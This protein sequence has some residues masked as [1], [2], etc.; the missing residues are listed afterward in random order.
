VK[1]KITTAYHEF[2]TLRSCSRAVT[3]PA[4][5]KPI[6]FA[7]NGKPL[8]VDTKPRKRMSAAEIAKRPRIADMD[9][10][11]AKR[12]TKL[13]RKAAPRTSLFK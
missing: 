13:R 7:N 3:T 6:W 9:P 4:N 11:F 10:S 12:E 5:W 8:N 2:N 1:V